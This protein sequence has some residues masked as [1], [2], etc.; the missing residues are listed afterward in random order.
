VAAV[1]HSNAHWRPDNEQNAHK[2]T[3]GV[4][5]GTYADVLAANIAA[6]ADE[7]GL[8]IKVIASGTGGWRYLDV[9]SSRAGKL[10]SL[11]YVRSML[12]FEPGATVS[13][14]DSGNDILLLSGPSHAVVVGN[15]Q[16][17]LALWADAQLEE[18][19]EE[20]GLRGRGFVEGPRSLGSGHGG[21]EQAGGIG[22]APAQ[23]GGAVALMD[24]PQQSGE[25][26]VG[27]EAGQ[28]RRRLYRAQAS[29]AWGIL[30]GLQHF[31]CA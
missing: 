8:L 16:P 5:E 9:V 6:S 11:E 12:G 2:L 24:A 13:A 30:E 14:G 7:A 26:A 31:G 4:K 15:A 27:A 28:R 29:H 10:E 20:E 22:V 18:E 23:E 3:L 19:E 25:A 17:D 21:S 1:G